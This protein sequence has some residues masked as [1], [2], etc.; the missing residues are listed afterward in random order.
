MLWI[1]T[2][3]ADVPVRIR[4]GVVHIHAPASIIETIVAIAE[5]KGHRPEQRLRAPLLIIYFPGI[6]PLGE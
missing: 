5:P 6:V 4:R 3:R 1:E 2:G